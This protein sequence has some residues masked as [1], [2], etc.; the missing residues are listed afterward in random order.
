M[1]LQV[2]EVVA[3]GLAADRLHP[4]PEA[5]LQARALVAREVDAAAALEELQ[6]CLERRVLGHAHAV[7]SASRRF[8]PDRASPLCRMRRMTA[9]RCS[10]ST[11][12]SVNRCRV[13]GW[14]SMRFAILRSSSLRSSSTSSA[15]HR[16]ASTALPCASTIA[17]SEYE[18][19]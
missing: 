12:P 7:A 5:A 10:A 17:S 15:V 13:R 11:A 8:R 19:P 16:A 4:A 2:V 9:A 18:W 14:S 6:Q 3:E 1:D